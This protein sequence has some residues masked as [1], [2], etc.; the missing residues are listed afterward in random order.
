[1]KG[2]D[3][4]K[5]RF[6]IFLSA[7]TVL[8]VL[9]PCLSIVKQNVELKD[10][11]H[12]CSEISDINKKYNS[13][14]EA[15]IADSEGSKNFNYTENRLIAKADKMPHSTLAV[16]TL[17][18]LDYTVLQYQNEG[19]ML[20]DYNRLSELGYTVEKDK[21]FYSFELN[22]S[23]QEI[24]AY[25]TSSYGWGFS[26]SGADYAKDIIENS[27]EVY[28]EIV[29]GV[30]D[31]GIDYT[32]TLYEGRFVENNVNFSTSGASNDPMDDQGHGTATSSIVVMSTPEN[33]KVKPYKILNKD[34]SCTLSEIVAACE[35]ILAEKDKP[36][37]INMS[38]G[39]YGFDGGREI[40]NEIIS[41]LIENGITVCAASGNDFLPA[42]YALPAGNDYVITVSS[43]NRQNVF[44][45][46]SN[47]GKAVDIC[48]PG[49]NIYC[50]DIGGGFSSQNKTGTSVACPFVSAACTYVLMQNPDA[51]PA[52]IKEKLKSTAI[53]MGDD[54][55]YYYGAGLLSFANLMWDEEY[56]VPV[57]TVTGG[58]YHDVQ[59]IEFNNIP[60]GTKLVYTTDRTV[61]SG[62]NGTEY[63]APITIDCDTQLN[64]ALMSVDYY[65]SP[66]SSQNYTIQYYADSSDFTILSGVITKY[67]SDKTNIIVP[68]TING[69]TPT[70]VLRSVFKNSNLTSI[71]LPDTVTTLG[72]SCFEGSTKLKHIV[73]NGVT[74]FSGDSVFSGCADLRDEVMPNLKTVTDFAFANCSRLHRIDFGNNITAFKSS[75]FSGSGLMYADFPNAVLK[76]N[77]V[78]YVFKDCP[79][80]SCNVP[81]VT[82]L[83]PSFLEG[84]S[85]L[86][87]L[88]IGQVTEIDSRALSNCW[89]INDLD[90]SELITISSSALRGCH[91]DTLYAPKCTSLPSGFGQYCYVR[92]IDL[93]N[94][95]G[96]LGSNMFYCAT[97]EELYLDKATAVTSSSAFRNTIAL[98]VVYL[99]NVTQFY[100]PYT[101]VDAIDSVLTG[102]FWAAEPPLDILWIPKAEVSSSV[103]LSDTQLL[104]AP[105]TSSLNVN[106]KN[107]NTQAVI[108]LSDKVADGN[109]TVTAA[110]INPIIIAP[111]DS[112]AQQYALYENCNYTFVS[113]NYCT[114]NGADESGNLIYTA[115]DDEFTVPLDFVIPCW[116]SGSFN[117][118]VNES[119]YEFLLDFTND[120]F[121]NAKDY[122]VLLRNVNGI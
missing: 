1:M 13:A 111:N 57:P 68:D 69:K 115:G 100:G 21:V 58:V 32:H 60:Y 34:G 90:T 30:M 38:L 61:P 7:L 50:A 114:Y 6:C 46:F 8:L 63:T 59:T 98:R 92:V 79:L 28:D 72:T 37:I 12:F 78:S 110:N 51:Q 70:S 66:I 56:S 18:G 109:L 99:P 80:Y 4:V 101:S 94:A 26:Q 75:L 96:T 106:I 35:Y 41:R 44:S 74:T 103:T 16:E 49:E 9:T 73:A 17:Y 119:L 86:C 76:D 3:F 22:S 67:N 77:S 10:V 42:E 31:T 62:T 81:K 29:V 39:G 97:T 53:P 105:S 116:D 64:F 52:D 45:E 82:V 84:C 104:F 48:A 95:V 43:H 54:D 88:T 108:V 11:F 112:Y 121:V 91:I 47:Y 15:M 117:K 122:S 85:C 20:K 40:E 113:A 93:P 120:N 24:S 2:G 5:K 71:V 118:T 87:E 89:F 14:P 107:E 102:D 23:E 33:V 19:D 55:S 36:D 65:A 83:G 25:T 27:G